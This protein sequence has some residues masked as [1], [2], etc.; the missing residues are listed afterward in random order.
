M[1][2]CKKDNSSVLAMELHLSCTNPSL[3]PRWYF[4]HWQDIVI[5]NQSPVADLITRISLLPYEFLYESML[6]QSRQRASRLQDH[7]ISEE[8]TQTRHQARCGHW[9]ILCHDCPGATG[10]HTLVMESSS[11]YWRCCL[12]EVGGN[13]VACQDGVVWVTLA[14]STGTWMIG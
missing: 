3:S 6:Q 12:V 10:G 5:L 7:Q 11:M 8:L 14:D 1:A 9:C 13:V 2:S 4:L